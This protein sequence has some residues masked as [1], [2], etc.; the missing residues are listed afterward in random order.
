M[1]DTSFYLAAQ[2]RT[3]AF[4]DGEGKRV[5]LH[6]W[7]G[8][9]SRATIPVGKVV[10]YKDVC[11]AVGGSPRSGLWKAVSLVDSKIDS[12]LYLRLEARC[13]LILL[14]PLSF[15][16]A[17]PRH[18]F[19]HIGRF[20]S[21]WGKKR[22][23]GTQ[24]NRKSDLLAKD[25]VPFT[26][27][28][29]LEAVLEDADRVLL[30]GCDD[31]WS[32]LCASRLYIT[33]QFFLANSLPQEFTTFHPAV[34]PDLNTTNVDNLRA[35]L[36]TSL[37]YQ[38]PPGRWL[39]RALSQIPHRRARTF[40]FV[41]SVTC[42]AASTLM[43]IT[44]R[45]TDSFDTAV[46]DWSTHSSGF[47]AVTYVHSCGLGTDSA[48]RSFHFVSDFV[49]SKKDLR[50]TCR[51]TSVSIHTTIDQDANIRI[52]VATY[53]LDDPAGPSPR[54]ASTFMPEPS[55]PAHSSRQVDSTHLAKRG[56]WS[57]VGNFFAKAAKV[58]AKVV[59]KAVKAVASLIPF[60][61]HPTLSVGFDTANI[62][63]FDTD[64]RG[65]PAYSLFHQE[66]KDGTSSCDL[67]C[68]GCGV[69]FVLTF[70][71]T[72]EG[73]K[74]ASL[75]LDMDLDLT[76]VLGIHAKYES[77]AEK[78]FLTIDAFIP[79][80]S[81]SL[82]GI[83]GI[84]PAVGLVVGGAYTINLDGYFEV[85][86]TCSWSKVGGRLD[87]LDSHHSEII[88]DWA[89]NQFSVKLK[90]SA[91]EKWTK[92][93]TLEAALVEKL[94]L[95]LKAE[96]ST[97]N[98]TCPSA[99]PYLSGTIAS[100]LYV[101]LTGF[102]DIPLHTP[103]TYSLF[104]FCLAVESN[105]LI[106]I[107]GGPTATN[108]GSVGGHHL[109]SQR[110]D[111]TLADETEGSDFAIGDAV[112]LVSDD[113]AVL[114]W[115]SDGNCIIEDI[116]SSATYS[117][118]RAFNG[119]IFATSR[120]DALYIDPSMTTA[121]GDTLGRLHVYNPDSDAAATELTP[122]V[123]AEPPNSTYVVAVDDQ[124]ALVYYLVQ[125]VYEDY[126]R[127]IFLT[128]NPDNGQVSLRNQTSITGEGVTE[129]DFAFFQVYWG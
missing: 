81:I 73:F 10:I 19:Q 56:F 94:S 46:H 27:D 17:A 36:I 108:D 48:E 15:A 125:C 104:G 33:N 128:T 45:D 75:S 30:F 16:T 4:Q 69:K 54:N 71:G 91:F 35:R 41:S 99:V 123:I 112:G 25:G 2:L 64:F 114:D 14:R 129:C 116:E 74:E 111:T 105:N 39:G 84:G 58:V 109:T 28:G 11:Q 6:Q 119:T 44:F 1:S 38:A 7:A 61:L 51:T 120:G 70:A 62:R 79:G 60:D 42:N 13:V 127:E 47:V 57:N 5:T 29:Y 103:F 76:L 24:C 59:V 32:F 88:G 22:R 21:E 53:R 82:A 95:T 115:N 93:L 72:L 26:D 52:H 55:S 113:G 31:L 9:T 63:K 92:A 98:G 89:P 77:K 50:I 3:A 23:T 101:A 8:M 97:T 34:H 18:C 102:N 20:L 85:G 96:V 121:S 83:C 117:G 78:D 86:F 37:Y 122:L 87:L 43:V 124:L 66:S 100:L 110:L 80:A 118:W 65:K 68:P 49:S 90:V 106:A 126:R 12:D 40:S 67:T 107:D